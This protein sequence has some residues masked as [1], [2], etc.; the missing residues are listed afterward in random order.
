VDFSVIKNETLR[1]L[2]G[3]SGKFAALEIEAQKEHLKAMSDITRKRELELIEFFAEQN[4]LELSPE[5]KLKALENV[6]HDLESINKRFQRIV[7]V[8]PEKKAKVKD[9]KELDQ[10][11]TELKKQ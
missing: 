3:E 10:I 2:V 6:A 11:I 9:S 8:Q 7:D 5:E 4:T 1:R